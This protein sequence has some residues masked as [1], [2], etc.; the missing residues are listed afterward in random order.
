MKK[1]E[2]RSQFD[3]KLLPELGYSNVPTLELPALPSVRQL[4]FNFHIIG[5]DATQLGTS[6]RTLYIKIK[7][8]CR[9]TVAQSVERPSK[10]QVLHD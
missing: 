1:K 5:R 3:L 8:R 2:N 10:I 6:L 4:S 9:D 7:E